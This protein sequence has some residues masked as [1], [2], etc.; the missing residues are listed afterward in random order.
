MNG[1][2]LNCYYIDFYS[3]KSNTKYPKRRGQRKPIP[4]ETRLFVNEI[5]TDTIDIFHCSLTRMDSHSQCI[6]GDDE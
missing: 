4:Y 6:L 2:R 5:W 3:L 1:P